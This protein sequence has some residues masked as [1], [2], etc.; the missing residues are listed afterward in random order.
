[1]IIDETIKAPYDPSETEFEY[2]LTVKI[3]SFKRMVED[4]T[5]KGEKFNREAQFVALIPVENTE[6][7]RFC[8]AWWPENAVSVDAEIVMIDSWG[9]PF[10]CYMDS[11]A[12]EIEG[13]YFGVMSVD[14]FDWFLS[15]EKKNPDAEYI[16]ITAK[17][18]DIT[19]GRFGDI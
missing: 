14:R 16:M 9:R 11:E 12:K 15:Q 13:R 7:Y 4:E 2:G 8:K 18:S 1:M 10:R 3:K 5:S 6:Y 17:A 19:N